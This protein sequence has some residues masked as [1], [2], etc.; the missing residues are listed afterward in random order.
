MFSRRNVLAGLAGVLIAGGAVPLAGRS[1]AAAVPLMEGDFERRLKT[2]E[3]ASG[4]R[5]GVAF[6]DKETGAVR[7]HRLNERFLMCST[8]KLLLVGAILSQVDSGKERLDRRIMIRSEDILEYAPVTRTHLDGPG[9]TVSE[10]CDAAMTLSDN[11]AANLLLDA[12]GGAETLIAF[13]R[14]LGDPVTRLD[15]KEPD[16]NLMVA[17]DIRDTTT[18]AAMAADLDALILG[19][20]L[21]PEMRHRLT[22]W[23]IG[24]Q[25]GAHRLRA[26]LPH[27]WKIGDKTGSGVG[28][29][30]D[31]A[32][33]WPP[34]R[35]PFLLSVYLTGATGTA[36]Q[37]DAVLAETARLA[38]RIVAA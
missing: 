24:N 18:P 23:L 19:D 12:L 22:K 36:V 38:A 17:D 6:V 13:A 32:L 35:A 11:T 1:P 2:L 27:G 21:S 16:L 25:T 7:G 9:M 14:S 5:L 34:G 30:N 28:I 4:G 8:F 26:G 3:T 15:R 37:S 33:V 20:R 29:A 31:V 10:L